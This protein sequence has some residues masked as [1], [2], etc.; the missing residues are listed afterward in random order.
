MGIKLR[1]LFELAAAAAHLAQ[2]QAQAQP[3]ALTPA[4]KPPQ[5]ASRPVPHNFPS[6]AFEKSSFHQ[7][8][9]PHLPSLSPSYSNLTSQAGNSTHPNTFSE[10]LV[11]ILQEKVGVPL[12]IRIGGTS[13]DEDHY[14]ASQI[15]AVVK[16]KPPD[17]HGGLWGY[18]K[19]SAQIANWDM[20]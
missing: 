14:N 6:L 10:A 11:N 5:G 15:A 3:I 9:G 1:Y 8:A 13:A 16:P 17:P 12:W 2:A 18:A 4:A 20:C 7:Y 19:L